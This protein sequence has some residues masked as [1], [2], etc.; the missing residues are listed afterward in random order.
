MLGFLMLVSAIVAVPPP[1]SYPAEIAD[2]FHTEDLV[3][4]ESADP[5]YWNPSCDVPEQ[6]AMTWIMSVFKEEDWQSAYGVAKWESAHTFSPL[7]DNRQGSDASGL[8]QHRKRYWSKDT[9]AKRE[10]KARQWLADHHQIIIEQPLDIYNGWH[11]TIVAAWLVYAGGGWTHFH[12]CL[13]GQQSF[14]AYVEEEIR[15]GNDHKGPGRSWK[16]WL[17]KNRNTGGWIKTC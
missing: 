5:C 4:V 17:A 14:N 6:A 13:S 15:K 10:W 12:S 1:V 8:F 16:N 2:Q 11:S 3:M 9:D 7:I